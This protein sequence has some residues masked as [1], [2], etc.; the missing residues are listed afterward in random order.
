M[1]FFVTDFASLGLSAPLLRALEEA[2]YA[3]PTPIQAQSI[4]LVLDGRDLLGIA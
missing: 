4:P 3:T 1:I 2:G